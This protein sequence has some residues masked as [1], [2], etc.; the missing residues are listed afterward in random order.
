VSKRRF[1]F[2][3]RRQTKKMTLHWGGACHPVDDIVCNV[4]CETKWNNKMPVL[5]L[6]GWANNVEI[7]NGK[8][9]IT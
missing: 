9:T 8:A 5:V 7:I 1:F 3:Y 2:H 4:D 6:Q